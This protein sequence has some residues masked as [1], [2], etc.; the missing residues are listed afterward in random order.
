[1]VKSV[2]RFF[3]F[4]FFS[5]KTIYHFYPD[6]NIKPAMRSLDQQLRQTLQLLFSLIIFINWILYCYIRWWILQFRG[7]RQEFSKIDVVWKKRGL[8]FLTKPGCSLKK[9][10][11]LHFYFISDLPI[12]LPKS[13]C[14]LKKKVF[15]QNRSLNKHLQRIQN[16]MSYFLGGGP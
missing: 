4:V 10:K 9:K 1:M 14:S 2:L 7:P 11:G 12:F 16:C 13:G 8:I 15:T 6:L 3:K 5:N